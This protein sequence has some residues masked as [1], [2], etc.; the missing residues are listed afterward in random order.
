MMTI[1]EIEELLRQAKARMDE[2]DS[3]PEVSLPMWVAEDL[4]SATRQL[5]NEQK[6]RPMDAITD[7]DEVVLMTDGKRR[8]MASLDSHEKH[9]D[10]RGWLGDD[11]GDA[12]GWLPLPPLPS[13]PETSDA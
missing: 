6:W 7:K 1:K 5:I 10:V 11:A 2:C 9:A 13:P 12:I 4:H 8:W 3:D